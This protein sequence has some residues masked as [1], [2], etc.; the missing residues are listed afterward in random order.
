MSEVSNINKK[1]KELDPN[2]NEHNLQEYN[3]D[4]REIKS[5]NE[6]NQSQKQQQQQEHHDGHSCGC[7]H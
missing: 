3:S 2:N 4:D 1:N 5:Q 7:G 6:K